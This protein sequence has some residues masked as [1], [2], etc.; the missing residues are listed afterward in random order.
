MTNSP[1][2]NSLLTDQGQCVE[3][4]ESEEEFAENISPKENSTYVII[5]E[6]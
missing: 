2:D 3:I 4:T 5:V 6:Y 1:G